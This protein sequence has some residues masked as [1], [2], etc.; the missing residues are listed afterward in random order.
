M[1]DKEIAKDSYKSSFRKSKTP[2]YNICDPKVKED[3]ENSEVEGKL[4]TDVSDRFAKLYLE[5]T[6]M[7][8]SN[9]ALSM[10]LDYTRSFYEDFMNT[11]KMS[12]YTLVNIGTRYTTKEIYRIPIDF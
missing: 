3:E 7:G 12:S 8:S 4:P 5:Y 10:C 6:P 1:G 9:L 11:D 2:N